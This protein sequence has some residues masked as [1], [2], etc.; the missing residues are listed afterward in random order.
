MSFRCIAQAFLP[1][2]IFVSVT[3]CGSSDN[4]PS[5]KEVA[6]KR[7]AAAR[8]GVMVTLAKDQYRNGD[9]DRARTTVDDAL[10]LSP[11]NP[12]ARLVSARL[13]IE[14]SQLESAER[15]LI[16]ARAITPNDGE[17]YYLSGIVMQRW[18][19]NDKALENYKIAC[20]KSPA[21]LAYVLAVAES[22]VSLDRANEALELLQSKADYFE[23][24]GTIRDAIGQLY[25]QQGKYAE[26]ARNFRQ[27]T[28]LAEDEPAIKERLA[29]ALFKAGQHRETADVLSK[30]VALET[31]AK[32]ADLWAMLGE[33]QVILGRARD[34]RYSYESA[35]RLDEF[36]PS[37][38]RGLGRAALES[39]DLQR[40]E[41]AFK[42]SLRFDDE[43][44]ET[45][46]LLGYLFTRQNKFDE[47]LQAFLA[48]SKLDPKDTV[49]LC[50]VGYVYEK[51][52]KPELAAKYYAR[53]LQI[54]PSD[55][56]ARKLMAG[57]E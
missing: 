21:E 10:R 24:S 42:K 13:Y 52:G 27:A 22:L 34:A 54:R 29:M 2:A 39:G 25:M 16:A 41:L 43:R 7:W 14:K 40:A 51:S 6:Q 48:A 12:Q 38:W 45:H 46:L 1:I 26:A 44:P 20:E 18:Q 5:E 28:V 23:H 17:A 3:G 50:M 36:S 33:C 53:A 30:L 55:E 19:K 9:L 4:K 57:V 47:A 35:S 15:E 37:I 56:M 49:A 11:E 32:R 31:F 8:S